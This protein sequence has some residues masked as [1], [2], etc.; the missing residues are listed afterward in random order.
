[1]L[2]ALRLTLAAVLAGLLAGAA[3]AQSGRVGWDGT[4]AGG[5]Q[6]GAGVQLTFVGD[7]LISFYWRDDYKDIVRSSPTPDGAGKTFTWAT[8]TATLTR[9]PR[10]RRCADRPRTR[11][12]G[13][14]GSPQARVT[15][16]RTAMSLRRLIAAG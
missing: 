11:R 4:W 7:K 8:G 6:S 10:R 1:M 9:D 5:W 14:V 2:G 12:Q 13:G 15:T 16:G 3:A